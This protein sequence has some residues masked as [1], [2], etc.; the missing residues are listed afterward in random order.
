LHDCRTRASRLGSD[1]GDAVGG[2]RRP[3]QLVSGCVGANLFGVVRGRGGRGMHLA[4]SW[5]T[6]SGVSVVA[7]P[8]ESG[9]G[10]SNSSD[11]EAIC[12]RTVLGEPTGVQIPLRRS[13]RA[14]D[15]CACVRGEIRGARRDRLGRGGDASCDG[16][17]RRVLTD[18][19][20]RRRGPTLISLS[21][22]RS[23][24]VVDLNSDDDD[25]RRGESELCDDRR[26]RPMI[27]I[28]TV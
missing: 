7:S 8:P 24:S 6:V 12:D 3:A 9:D 25:F 22:R 4:G 28:K 13:Q 10:S 27:P 2:A 17:T 23:P 19:Q 21:H 5:P 16:N 1:R 26:W 18:R 15:Q 14:P 11:R 20:P